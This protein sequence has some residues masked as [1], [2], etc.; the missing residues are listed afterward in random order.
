M[1]RD[2]H[3][4]FLGIFTPGSFQVRERCLWLPFQRDFGEINTKYSTNSTP[5]LVLIQELQAL[6]A[7][8]VLNT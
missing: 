1:W 7:G 4:G 6:V 3:E 5:E 8:L 2:A